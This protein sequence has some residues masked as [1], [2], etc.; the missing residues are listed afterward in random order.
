V[1]PAS[2]SLINASLPRHSYPS[3]LTRSELSIRQHIARR[4]RTLRIPPPTSFLNDLLEIGIVREP[5]LNLSAIVWGSLA[6]HVADETNPERVRHI[7]QGLLIEL[8]TENTDQFP[9]I[10]TRP[11]KNGFVI[12]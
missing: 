6:K 12:Y 11:L 5:L 8:H 1:Y 3:C 7:I 9:K 10:G 4:G 2:I